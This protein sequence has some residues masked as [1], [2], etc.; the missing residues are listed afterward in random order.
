MNDLWI[1]LSGLAA[2]M[3]LGSIMEICFGKKGGE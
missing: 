3:W 2:G 1:Y